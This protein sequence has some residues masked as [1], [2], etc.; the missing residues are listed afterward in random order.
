MET[1]EVNSMVTD[2]MHTLNKAKGRDR[3][4]RSTENLFLKN[5]GEN[6]TLNE[7]KGGVTRLVTEAAYDS[8]NLKPPSVC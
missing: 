1:S 5:L 8:Y 7:M 2:I 6:H 4:V 3:R